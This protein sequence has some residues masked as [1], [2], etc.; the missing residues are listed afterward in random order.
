MGSGGV[1]PVGM[2][3]EPSQPIEPLDADTAE[4]LLSGRLDP[5]DAPPGYAEVTRL[6]RTAAAPADPAE[7]TGEAAA[8]AAFRMA[9]RPPR[10]A[11]RLR[12]SW[13]CSGEASG[14][15]RAA[16]GRRVRSTARR[17]R[18][19]GRLAALA[20]AGAVAVAGVGMWTAGGAPFPGERRSPSGGPSASGPGSGTPAS[21][22]YGSAAYGSGVGGAGSLR[23]ASPRGPGSA[24]GPVSVTNGR[25]PSLPS[26]RERATARPGA[27]ETSPGSGSPHGTK[28][29]RPAKPPKPKPPKPKPPKPKP[30]KG[31]MP[32]AS[33]S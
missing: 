26:A 25:P 10:P 1:F 32:K 16:S 33:E 21:A 24:P 2:S 4:R 8:L 22:A 11:G 15:P 9:Q 30:P 17:G 14:H 19:R 31:T 20:L 7:L 13:G 6:L 28:P 18:V 5:D 3:E 23:P 29:P 12:K 27:G